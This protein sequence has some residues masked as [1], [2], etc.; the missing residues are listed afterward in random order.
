V[1]RW[2]GWVAQPA[3]FGRRYR[4]GLQEFRE[5]FFREEERR[6]A[7]A[8]EAALVAAQD[9]ARDLSIADLMEEL[10][11]GLRIENLMNRPRLMLI[12]CYWCS[13]RV[14]HGYFGED[15]RVVLF[16]ARPPDASLVPEDE[17]PVSL[18]LAL[19]A[20]ADGTRLNILR[21]LREESLTQVQMARRLRLRP[22]T[23]SHHLKSL[24]MAGLIILSQAEGSETRYA[25]RA[26][27][28]QELFES[29]GSFLKL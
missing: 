7:P 19:A 26:A 6:I 24:R 8:L 4:R 27:R 18:S 2:L 5:S 25:T 9:R 22:S 20:L 3:E 16:G 1:E 12:P 21:I 23:I 14:L 17:V 11:Q 29:L 10:S 15:C 28:I 13:P